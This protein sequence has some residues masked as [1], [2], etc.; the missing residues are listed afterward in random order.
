MRVYTDDVKEMDRWITDEVLF[1]GTV[2]RGDDG[3]SV[4][5][6][7]EWLN[8]HDFGT[9]IDGD[10]G[11][12][13]ERQVQRF[14]NFTGLEE[15]GSVDEATFD[16][17]VAPMTAVLAQRL[18]ASIPFGEAVQEYARA[19]LAV[20]PREVGGANRGPWVRLY[21]QGFEGSSALWCA[22]FV[23]F[24]MGQAADSLQVDLPIAGSFSCDTLAGQAKTAGRFVA[25]DDAPSLVGPGS[26]FLVR[27]TS[28]DWTHTGL[29]T[30][31]SDSTIDTIEGNTND[32]GDR[33]GYEVCARTRGWTGKDYVVLD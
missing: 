20:H 27:N 12:A 9:G 31:V 8:L 17:L 13:T 1:A 28:T 29:I 19:H 21:M 16:A 24:V 5:R 4:R 32:D 2:A 30:G 25:E 10:F 22:G 26:L 3:R 18:N 23:T 15:S 7:Q 14:Q 33:E 6:V 11:P